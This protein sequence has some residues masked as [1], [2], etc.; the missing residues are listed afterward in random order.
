MGIT[1]G[2]LAGGAGRRLGGRD[3]GWLR[4]AQQPL[5]LHVVRR[6]EPQVDELL[7]S[8]NRNLSAYRELPVAQVLTD[9]E[10]DHPGPMQGILRL[11]QAASH[12][13]LLIVPCDCP[14]L[15][16]DLAMRLWQGLRDADADI[17]V[18]HDGSYPQPLFALLKTDEL[19]IMQQ[20]YESGLR[21]M[22]V[23]LT[24]RKTI[25]ADFADQPK[26]FI[27]LNTPE[28]FAALDDLNV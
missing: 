19:A 25:A 24:Q 9:D 4:L 7:I 15:P 20:A 16:L 3:K 12:P 18:A 21:S 11:L 13:L 10:Q 23:Y 1:G 17:A 2:I 5:I 6:L 14:H 26:A 8:A 27:N 28:D 22:K